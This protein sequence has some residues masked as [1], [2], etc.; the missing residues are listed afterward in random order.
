MPVPLRPNALP[1]ATTPAADDYVV[2]DGTTNGTR[3]L[4]ASKLDEFDDIV[5]A[6]ANL[7][8]DGSAAL[9]AIYLVRTSTGTWFVNRKQRGMYQRV[10]TTGTRATDWE[11]MGEWLEEFSDA[12]LAIY[13]NSDNSKLLGF[14]LSGATASTKTTLAFAQ[15]ANR[16]ITFPDATGTL[17]YGGG[18]L[19]TP[20]SGVVTN[21][22]GTAS[23]NIN[24]TV[25]ATTPNTGAFTTLSSKIAA[26]TSPVTLTNA[27]D[28]PTYGILSLNGLV[29]SSTMVGLLGGGG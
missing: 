29:A 24:G 19:G 9:N 22:T 20:S 16:T 4:L 21:L 15:T 13:N 12:N 28:V 17:L 11:Y 7:P 1:L 18:P 3:R 14:T 25:G 5:T 26:A 8:V 2:I 27:S 23:I 10:A 6:Y